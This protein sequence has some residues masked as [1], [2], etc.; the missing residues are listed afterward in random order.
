M[1]D[2]ENVLVTI[3][4]KI[5]EVVR[6]MSSD[7]GSK[8]ECVAKVDSCL[9]HVDGIRGVVEAS[10][11]LNIED[12]LRALRNQLLSESEQTIATA[13]NSNLA[14]SFSAP[15]PLSGTNII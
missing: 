13:V 1:D 9:T 15:R 8:D 4:A 6:I 11:V 12:C 10:R 7:G 3:S 2:A 14:S 5:R